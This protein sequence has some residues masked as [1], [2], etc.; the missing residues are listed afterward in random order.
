LAVAAQAQAPV[1]TSI[2]QPAAPAAPGD[3]PDQVSRAGGRTPVQYPPQAAQQPAQQPG[4]AAP[5]RG[6]Y[7]GVGAAPLV[8]GGITDAE[9]NNAP[10]AEA[11]RQMDQ[12]LAAS[13]VTARADLQGRQ[14]AIGANTDWANA[15]LRN[16]DAVSN[17]RVA[18]F[19]ATN[20]ADMI[21]GDRG[22]G[23]EDQRA[24]I[25]ETAGR[26]A[27]SRVGS[28]LAL[29]RASSNVGIA[30]NRDPYADA[31]TAGEV[32]N[33]GDIT[34][35]EVNQRNQVTGQRAAEAPTDLAQKQQNVGIG[36]LALEGQQRIADV[37]KKLTAATTTKDIDQYSRQIAGLLGKDK[38]DQYKA[39]VVHG[40]ESVDPLTNAKTKAPDRLFL[41]GPDGRSEDVTAAAAPKAP[42]AKLPPNVTPEAA[43]TNAQKL[44][45]AGKITREQANAELQ[46]YG[47]S[48]RI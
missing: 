32:A 21:L 5:T 47:L 36:K 3:Y 31:K 19:R 16:R 1:P 34:A 15:W 24:A 4:A 14:A 27:A 9:R 41:I 35:A 12:R 29:E 23:Y 6:N 20:G 7:S 28:E 25:R 43:V 33:R 11:N 46:S 2:A 38:P 18:Q 44:V 37:A 48:Q 8:P 17:D 42:Q 40:E 30:G 10:W 22:G 13:N 26:T 39:Y 45:K